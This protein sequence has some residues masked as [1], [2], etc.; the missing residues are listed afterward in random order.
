MSVARLRN[1]LIFLLFCILTEREIRQAAGPVAQLAA[2][3]PLHVPQQLPGIIAGETD[4]SQVYSGPSYFHY[5]LPHEGI[6]R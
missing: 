6:Q 3:R 4:G 1:E 5:V 2:Y